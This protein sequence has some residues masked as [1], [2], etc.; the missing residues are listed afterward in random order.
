MKNLKS[1]IDNKLSQMAVK[2][3]GLNHKEQ[4][5]FDIIKQNWESII[6]LVKVI[7]SKKPINPIKKGKKSLTQTIMQVIKSFDSLSFEKCR[8]TLHKSYTGFMLK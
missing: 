3:T 7:V 6:A 2:T 5:K 4:S 1:I 8:E